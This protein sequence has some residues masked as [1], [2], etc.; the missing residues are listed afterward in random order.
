MNTGYFLEELHLLLGLSIGF[1]DNY[2]VEAQP[3]I[4]SRHRG[5]KHISFQWLTLWCCLMKHFCS[6]R[7]QV[8]VRNNRFCLKVLAIK[9]LKISSQ[10]WMFVFCFLFSCLEQTQFT[11]DRHLP[12]AVVAGLACIPVFTVSLQQWKTCPIPKWHNFMSWCSSWEIP[13]FR[14]TVISYI[15]M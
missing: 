9:V 4:L 14:Q 12:D 10:Q 13:T 8:E 5:C 11:I 3:D 1:L 6:Y 7:I 15:L 2:S